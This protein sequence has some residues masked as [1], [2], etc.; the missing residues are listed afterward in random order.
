MRALLAGPGFL[1][2]L[3]LGSASDP[4]ADAAQALTARRLAGQATLNITR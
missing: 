2:R 3:R 4:V 1:A